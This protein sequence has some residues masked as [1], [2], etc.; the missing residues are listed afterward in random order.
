MD[1]ERSSLS[2]GGNSIIKISM[3]NGD[4]YNYNQAFNPP[5]PN[6]NN[7]NNNSDFS[8]ISSLTKSSSTPIL[9]STLP[10][11]STNYSPSSL[12]K[13]PIITKGSSRNLLTSIP[14]A[15][16]L[17]T[18]SRSNSINSNAFDDNIDSYMTDEASEI[19]PQSSSTYYSPTPSPVNAPLVTLKPQHGQNHGRFVSGAQFRLLS[20]N[21]SVCNQCESNEK[22]IKKL[23]ET[24]RSLKSIISRHE[25]TLKHLKINSGQSDLSF[26][27]TQPLPSVLNPLPQEP[28]QPEVQ[29]KIPEVKQEPP[30]ANP[31]PATT[32]RVGSDPSFLT[33]EISKLK[34]QLN[35]EKEQAGIKYAKLL[36]ES[37]EL[38][39]TI[40]KLKEEIEEKNKAA[41]A[42][43]S[44]LDVTENR[45]RDTQK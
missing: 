2:S 40:E 8:T 15:Y 33:N 41:N 44:T 11:M 32:G 35:E 9:S 4:T 28:Q 34:K 27:I 6:H 18:K 19:Y 36:N 37:N 43:K 3:M 30:K 21:T 16:T 22:I 10:N 26:P 5:M 1:K 39:A 7:N 31:L 23:K 25:E 38:E 13:P 29:E 42:M 14:S 17:K 12:S 24:I 45:L 20:K